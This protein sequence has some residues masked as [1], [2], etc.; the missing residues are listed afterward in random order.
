MPNTA[1][2]WSKDEL[3]RMQAAVEGGVPSAEI[4]PRFATSKKTVQKL[5][6][7]KGWQWPEYAGPGARRKGRGSM[8]KPPKPIKGRNPL[9]VRPPPTP[10]EPKEGGCAVRT[11]T[12][13]EFQK[14]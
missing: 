9:F 11:L 1:R 12:G 5:A 10:F 6:A 3:K 13:A 14:R 2:L 4:A 7:V 8:S